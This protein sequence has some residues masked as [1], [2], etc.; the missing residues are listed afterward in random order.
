M[1]SNL[2]N[3]EEE[4]LICLNMELIHADYAPFKRHP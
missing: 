4:D 1:H 3:K 2:E